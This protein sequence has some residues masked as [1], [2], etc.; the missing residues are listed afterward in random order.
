MSITNLDNMKKSS[1]VKES[2]RILHE[3]YI[4]K[5]LVLFIGAGADV[6]SGLPLWTDAVKEF[7]DHMNINS[8]GADNLR[9]PQYYYNSRGKRNMLNCVEIFFV[10][11]KSSLSIKF[12]K[13]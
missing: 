12:T 11:I 5:K 9:I 6:P 8:D 10:I 4:S 13:K 2:I 1:F 7:S 3:A